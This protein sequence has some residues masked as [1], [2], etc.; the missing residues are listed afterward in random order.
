MNEKLFT[1][2]KCCAHRKRH[3][4]QQTWD[5]S[6]TMNVWFPF[7]VFGRDSDSFPNDDGINGDPLPWSRTVLKTHWYSL[8][9]NETASIDKCGYENNSKR[10]KK[11][12]YNLW[13]FSL[14]IH[15][16]YFS[17]FIVQSKCQKI[18][19]LNIFSVWDKGNKNAEICEISWWELGLKTS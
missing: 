7:W 17:W 6:L 19:L 10:T 5:H 8:K 18:V 9:W 3:L 16:A 11:K 12:G 15:L 14:L 13:I 1:E 2:R 4:I